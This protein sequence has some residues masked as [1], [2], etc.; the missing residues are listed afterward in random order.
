MYCQTKPYQLAP[1]HGRLHLFVDGCL[2]VANSRDQSLSMG[3]PWSLPWSLPW[4][5]PT[6]PVFHRH[7]FPLFDGSSSKSG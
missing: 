6:G 1:L 3:K 4:F 7:S 2:G 5:K